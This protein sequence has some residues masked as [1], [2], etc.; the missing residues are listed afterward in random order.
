MSM[1]T[2]GNSM[3][4]LLKDFDVRRINTG[5]I[6]KGTVID[7]NESEVSVNINYAFDGLI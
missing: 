5:D 7:V 3:E 1:E 6:L 2:T 4:E